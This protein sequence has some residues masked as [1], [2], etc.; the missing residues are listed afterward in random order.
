MRQ[1]RHQL[2]LA[3]KSGAI[4]RVSAQL[5]GEY[6]QGVLARQPR[7]LDKID[8]AHPT[9]TQLAHD[10]VPSKH[11]THRQR[12]GRNRTSIKLHTEAIT[13]DSRAGDVRRR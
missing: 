3:Q 4:L 1:G 8:R 5:W 10:G 6:L 11:L 2:G 13:P 7:V 12:H 9:G